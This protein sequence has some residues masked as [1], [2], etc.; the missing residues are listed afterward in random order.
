MVGAVIVRLKF[1]DVHVNDSTSF[2]NKE[3]RPA[4]N[5]VRWLT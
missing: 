2:M 4:H 1:W 5:A 3:G